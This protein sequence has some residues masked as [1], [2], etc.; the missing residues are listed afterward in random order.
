LIRGVLLGQQGGFGNVLKLAAQYALARPHSYWIASANPWLR[1]GQTH[2]KE[3]EPPRHIA[4]G[5]AAALAVNWRASAAEAIQRRK[6][7]T[8][9]R[10]VLD[11]VSDLSIPESDKRGSAGYIR[12]PVVLETDSHP[13]ELTPGVAGPYPDVISR[14]PALDRRIRYAAYG[15]GARVLVER[16]RT[17]PTHRWADIRGLN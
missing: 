12:F 3:P 10:R 1:L 7:A 17:L 13:V 15:S 9:Y 5:S 11:D 4:R 8:A 16:L 14:L 6:R 2:Y